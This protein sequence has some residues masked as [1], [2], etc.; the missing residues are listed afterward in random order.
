MFGVEVTEVEEAEDQL[1]RVGK[2]LG[3]PYSR[4]SR[5]FF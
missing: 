1:I 4:S 5:S 2:Y 3:I